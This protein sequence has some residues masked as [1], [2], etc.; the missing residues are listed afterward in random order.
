MG[1]ISYLHLTRF[2]RML[3]DRKDRMS[4]AVVRADPS[5][6]GYMARYDRERSLDLAAW[7]DIYRPEV[8]TS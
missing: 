4:M 1:V 8:R 2:A 6:I 5:S 3:W 7:L